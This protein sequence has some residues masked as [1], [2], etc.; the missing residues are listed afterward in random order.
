MEDPKL[1]GR[2]GEGRCRRFLRKKGLKTIARNFTCKAG[3][4]DLVARKS[5]G[6]IVFVE[7]K[8]RRNE[9]YAQAQDAITKKKKTTMIR[10]AKSFLRKYKIKDKPLRF[11][12]VAVILGRKGP[13]EI[14]HYENAFTPPF[15]LN[16]FDM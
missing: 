15:G 2:W 10:A 11:D 5:D 9:D 4:I 1:L 13:P 7:V 12:V 3:E 6:T 8:T 14:R 16:H